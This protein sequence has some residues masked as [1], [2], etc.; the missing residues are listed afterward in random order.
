M[1]DELSA[2]RS[3]KVAGLALAVVAG[4]IAALLLAELLTRLLAPQHLERGGLAYMDDVVND[5]QASFTGTFSYPD[6]AYT[7]HTDAL[8]LRKTWGHASAATGATVLILGDSFAHG[9]GVDDEQTIPSLVARGLSERD[10]RARV[11]NG[12]VPGYSP[13]E[14]LAKF[15]RVAPVVHPDVVV[16]VLSFND[17]FSTPPSQAGAPSAPGPALDA[18]ARVRARARDFVLG[19]S[20]FGV[21]LAYRINTLLIR[22]G[23]RPHFAATASAYDP[24][25]YREHD[26]MVARTA[27]V[28]EHLRSEARGAGAAVVL[29]YVPGLLEADDR[30]WEA[31]QR[32]AGG[33]LARAL[34]RERVVA[35]ARVAGFARVVA[36]PA[37]PSGRTAM[38]TLYFPLDMHLTPEGNAYVAGLVIE[39]VAPLLP[40]R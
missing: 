20:H 17:A 19:H 37:D 9:I 25:A 35:A 22:R 4:S 11:L 29:V 34:P 1:V 3:R 30:V 36:P 23:L 13:T 14:A 40:P 2:A 39:A 21:L 26:A 5:L 6:Y 15:R 8:R 16:L 33:R 31:A 24:R 38:Q 27:V 7:V 28:L 32:L 12:A 10:V 18:V